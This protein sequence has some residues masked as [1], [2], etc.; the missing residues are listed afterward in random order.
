MEITLQLPHGEQRVAVTGPAERNL[1]IIRETLG[2]QVIARNGSL[3]ISGDDAAVG[4]AAQV[5][6]KLVDAAIR[7]EPMSRKQVVEII[8]TVTSHPH[9]GLA[10]S[11][12]TRGTRTQQPDLS[13]G[14]DILSA[15]QAGQSPD[16]G[17]A[18]VSAG[19]F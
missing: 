9:A 11:P 19:Y 17:S 14:L 2:V 16:T 8:A 13:A 10:V 3:K 5:F 15:G 12:G 18:G 6:E 4:Q 1:K 7:N